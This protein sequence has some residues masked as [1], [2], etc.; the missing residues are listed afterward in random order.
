VTSVLGETLLGECDRARL[1]R[2]TGCQSIER[3]PRE[4]E[5]LSRSRRSSRLD[6]ISD[7]SSELRRRS[8]ATHRVI[9][10]HRWYLRSATYASLVTGPIRSE[11]V[12][13]L[14]NIVP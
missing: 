4:P 14:D 6:Q 9:H 3:M 13:T 1:H 10:E 12:Q 5:Y 2:Q 8:D 11:L 7:L